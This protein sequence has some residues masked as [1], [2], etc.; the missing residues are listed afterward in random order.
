MYQEIN[1]K[2][3]YDL[4]DLANK[5]HYTIDQIYLLIQ[6]NAF[7]S[8]INYPLTSNQIVAYDDVYVIKNS[9]QLTPAKKA[10]TSSI[11]YYQIVDQQNIFDAVIQTYGS[12]DNAYK[13]I[14]DSAIGNINEP[15]LNGKIVNF[16]LNFISDKGFYGSINKKKVVIATGTKGLPDTISNYT[17][18][19][20]GF[21]LLRTDGGGIPR[22]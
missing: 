20:D 1:V 13:L 17:L 7:I 2:T 22:L 18:R 9:P 15:I 10:L 21:K 6:Q 5:S 16:N 12:L 4:F 14:Q 11:I 3:G 19:T 8:S